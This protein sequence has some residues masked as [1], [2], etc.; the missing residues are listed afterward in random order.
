METTSKP[1]TPSTPLPVDGA[2]KPAGWSKWKFLLYLPAVI[3]GLSNTFLHLIKAK[4]HKTFTI[5]YP[6]VKRQVRPGYRGEHRLKKDAQG[7]EKC[8]ACFMCQTVCP[9]LC[10]RI[11]AEEAPWNDRDKRP[12]TF[13]ID[14]LRCIYCGMCEEACPCDAIELTEK[15]NV[16]S[17][18]RAEKIYDKEKLLSN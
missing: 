18:S 2:G 3:K 5:Q 9:A 11:V 15:F 10:I 7:R 13:E 1:A 17:T 8:V 4:G 6:E 12:K 16:V 14:M